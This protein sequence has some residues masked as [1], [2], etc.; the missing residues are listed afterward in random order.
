MYDGSIPNFL[1]AVRQFLNSVFLQHWIARGGPTAGLHVQLITFLSLGT[2]E[3]YCLC[4]SSSQICPGTVGNKLI[5]VNSWSIT[6]MRRLTTG[7]RS[8][9]CVVRRFR[10]C[11]NGVSVVCFLLG[12]SPGSEFYMPTF[13]NTLSIPSS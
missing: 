8:E 12:N 2:F 4:C 5:C 13:R 6:V 7:I 1:L 9:K 3:F 10:R 11:A